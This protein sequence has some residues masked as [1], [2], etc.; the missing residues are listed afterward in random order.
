M[1]YHWP[2]VLALEVSAWIGLE[3]EDDAEST[4]EK[5]TCVARGVEED[6]S[7]CSP[8]NP[9]KGAPAMGNAGG[10]GWTRLVVLL[11]CGDWFR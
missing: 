3:H 4:T 11:D 6:V 8:W 9:W 5:F 10:I 7:I 1:K 2:L